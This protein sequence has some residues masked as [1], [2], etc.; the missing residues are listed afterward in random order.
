MHLPRITLHENPDLL[1]PV[2]ALLL[3]VVCVAK[4]IIAIPRLTRRAC[5]IWRRINSLDQP[6]VVLDFRRVLASASWTEAAQARYRLA[7]DRKDA[8]DLESEFFRFRVR[9]SFKSFKA[10]G[11]AVWAD[12][13]SLGAVM[14]QPSLLSIEHSPTL[15]ILKVSSMMPGADANAF[16][17]QRVIELGCGLGVTSMVLQRFARPRTLLATDGDANA[18]KAARANV[19]ANGCSEGLA[20]ERLRWGHSEDIAAALSHHSGRANDRRGAEDCQRIGHARYDLVM[21]S[22]VTYWP[23]PLDLLK[24]T[25]VQVVAKETGTVIIA[26]KDRSKSS[27]RD[28][29]DGLRKCFRESAHAKVRDVADS[30]G[31]TGGDITEETGWF[32]VF[33]FRGLVEGAGR[34]RRRQR[35]RS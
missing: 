26:H 7:N 21:M 32:H 20:V 17:H 15:S 3:S 4:V 30:V 27:G 18:V 9:Q 22:D 25:I 12:S 19:R 8:G 10:T 16:S 24:E 34:R 1:V 6:V 35:H 33:V 28:F 11:L 29:F 13:V 31:Q 5:S 23:A 2:A 14:V